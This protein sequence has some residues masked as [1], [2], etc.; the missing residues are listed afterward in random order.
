MVLIISEMNCN[1]K[2]DV[3]ITHEMIKIAFVIILK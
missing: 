1:H 3:E 2:G